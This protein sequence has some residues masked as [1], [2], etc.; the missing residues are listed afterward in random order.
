MVVE[1]NAIFTKGLLKQQ[2]EIKRRKKME[3]DTLK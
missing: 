3:K 2:I 1:V